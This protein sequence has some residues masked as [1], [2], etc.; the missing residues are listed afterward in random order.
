[1]RWGTN[2]VTGG[3]GQTSGPSP[4]D[5]LIAKSSAEE[6]FPLS[7]KERAGVRMGQRARKQKPIL[8][9]SFPL[10]GKGPVAE[11]YR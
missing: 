10:K 7:F 4:Y 6:R 3:T 1:M 5:F 11:D 2:S 9:L 8:I